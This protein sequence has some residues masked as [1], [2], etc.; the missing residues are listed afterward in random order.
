MKKKQQKYWYD[1][2][3]FKILVFVFIAWCLFYSSDV[4]GDTYFVSKSSGDDDND[5]L[6]LTECFETI[7]HAC[8]TAV[9]GDSILILPAWYDEQWDSGDNTQFTR[10]GLVGP[11]Y[12]HN[13]GTSDN[14]IVFMAYDTTIAGLDRPILS[15]KVNNDYPSDSGHVPVC[16]NRDYIKVIRLIA[17]RGRMAGLQVYSGTD[18]VHFIECV[19]CSNWTQPND[20]GGGIV[21]YHAG[22][23][24]GILVDACTTYHNFDEI[25]LPDTS[26]AW[27][28]S[29]IHIY[30]TTNSEFKN[31]VIFGQP[32]GFGLRSKYLYNKY[33]DIH[34][35]LFYGCAIALSPKGDSIWVHHNTIVDCDVGMNYF[36]SSGSSIESRWTN[37]YNNTFYHTGVAIRF[38]NDEED[39][40]D[41]SVFNNLSI[42]C[43]IGMLIYD[44]STYLHGHYSDYNCFWESGSDE[45]RFGIGSE[46]PTLYTLSEWQSTYSH[47]LN[48]IDQNPLCA[49]TLIL[50]FSI[51][52]NSPCAT[53]G[54]GGGRDSYIGAFEPEEVDTGVDGI[55]YVSGT[56]GNDDWSGKT[57]DSCWETCRHACSLATPGDTINILPAE[58]TEAWNP[59]EFEVVHTKDGL[60]GPLSPLA[61]G[62]SESPIVYIG[63]DTTIAGL[64]R[65]HLYGGVTVGATIDSGHAPIYVDAYEYV[66]FHRL[67][68]KYG[69]PAGGHILGGSNNI[70]FV[71]CVACTNWSQ[72]NDNGGGLW[73]GY[74]ANQNQTVD[75]CTLFNNFDEYNVPDTLTEWN[76]SGIHVYRSSGSIFS[77]NVCYGNGFGIRLKHLDTLCVVSGNTVRDNIVGLSVGSGGYDDSLKNN[78]IFDNGVGI[79]IRADADLFDSTIIITVFNN[80]VYGNDEGI[81]VLAR[82]DSVRVLHVY[83]NIFS[84]NTVFAHLY[85]N[86]TDEISFYDELDID[87]NDIWDSDSSGMS[88][89]TITLDDCYDDDGWVCSPTYP[90]VTSWSTTYSQNANSISQN[91]GFADAEAHDFSITASSPCADS[92]IGGG[93]PSYIGAYEPEEVD[94]SLDQLL[95]IINV[96]STSFTVV[97]DFSYIEGSLAR[98]VL[99]LDVSTPPTTRI[100]SIMSSFTDPDSFDVSGLSG[101]TKYYLRTIAWDDAT[102]DTSSISEQTTDESPQGVIRLCP[103]LQ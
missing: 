47:D 12:P 3:W 86:T 82:S 5:G 15:G 93:L 9:A 72:N 17:R 49:D 41:D 78:V 44:Y 100:D 22:G 30:E 85:Y 38:D 60:V 56:S 80:T 29:G 14:W 87:Y 99:L 2:L 4:L 13:S 10:D 35:N 69:Y 63:Y 73:F 103:I 51:P 18:Y 28:T 76:V 71:E 67:I 19:S 33:L 81:R 58:Y 94:T 50:D 75:A 40:R 90:T 32:N 23:S 21:M 55:Y 46:Y 48:S 20:N 34:D 26:D 36:P 95:S 65:P 64:D 27:N 83:N 7:R 61:S 39:V 52:A 43:D 70:S 68:M 92:G 42:G 8:S 101:G 84:D 45:D 25:M 59:P 53:N 31:N 74:S 66:E 97:D 6:A 24:E 98:I 89:I 96:D 37:T 57:L 16:I 54:I 62:T 77:D 1:K 102:T 88:T 79:D 11:L 91:P